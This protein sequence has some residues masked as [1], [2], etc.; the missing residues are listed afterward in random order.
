M[1]TSNTHQE[2]KQANEETI[3]QNIK[4]Y[5]LQNERAIKELNTET[6]NTHQLN[7]RMI[8]KTIKRNAPSMNKLQGSAS[9]ARLLMIHVM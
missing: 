4:N 7:L 9:V 8:I 1:K 2:I 5:T 3:S 6:T